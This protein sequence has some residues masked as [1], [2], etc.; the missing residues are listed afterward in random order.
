MNCDSL[1]S[2]SLKPATLFRMAPCDVLKPTR[3]PAFHVSYQQGAYRRSSAPVQLRTYTLH[4]LR[5]NAIYLLS[6]LLALSLDK[7]PT[8]VGIIGGTGT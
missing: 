1:K 6:S 3:A 5:P 2:I 8:I 4:L 7:S